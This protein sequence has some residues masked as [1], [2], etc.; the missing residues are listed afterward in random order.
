MKRIITLAFT[1]LLV[2]L[3]PCFCFAEVNIDGLSYDELIA[4]KD[5]IN[6]AIWSSD[7]W[8][9]VEVPQGVWKVGEDIPAGKWTIL[10][11]A[12]GE[13]RVYVGK[14]VDPSGTEVE[15]WIAHEKITSDTYRNYSSSDITEWTVELHDG[16]YVQVY[17][18]SV[19]FTP[20]SG[21]PTFGF[22]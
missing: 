6:L 8:Q 22:K 18:D 13:P 9:E 3:I 12:G 5:K 19:I 16:N 7:E 15:S 17:G 11:R 14:S 4:L 1:L 20:Y 10:P 2:F 21:K